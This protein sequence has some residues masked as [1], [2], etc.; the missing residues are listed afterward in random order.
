MRLQETVQQPL[1]RTPPPRLQR[2]VDQRDSRGFIGSAEVP[3]CR[4]PRL[5]HAECHA[6]AAIEGGN[7]SAEAISVGPT[8]S[9]GI[10]Q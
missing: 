1:G 2:V 7:S 8:G 6:L 4:V 10:V 5:G 3:A 9:C